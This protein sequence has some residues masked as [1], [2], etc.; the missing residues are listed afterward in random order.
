MSNPAQKALN[1]IPEIEFYNKLDDDDVDD[2]DAPDNNNIDHYLKNCV[3]CYP[4]DYIKKYVRQLVRNYDNY[5]VHLRKKS[6]DKYCR[7][8]IYWLYKSKKMKFS[9]LDT[10]LRNQ[11][12]KCIPCVWNQL[13]DNAYNQIKKC[14]FK[15]EN[16][17]FGVTQVQKALEEICSIKEKLK[18]DSKENSNIEECSK[19]NEIKQYYL[20]HI[21]YYIGSIS[22]NSSWKNEYFKVDN[23]CSLINIY[24]FLQEKPCPTEVKKSCPEPEVHTTLSPKPEQYC[25]TESCFN[26]T[27][28]RQKVCPSQSSP[29]QREV[30][31][32]ECPTLTCKNVEHICPQLCTKRQDP[33]PV[34]EEPQGN[35]NKNPLL[36][37]PVTVLSSVV[38][39]IFFFLLLYKFTPFRSWF[40]NRIG[41]KKTLNHKMRQEM[42]REFLG[43]PF[44]P[45]YGND[46]NSRPRVGYSQN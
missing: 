3:E 6:H 34:M 46:Q 37:V 14:N 1:E 31:Q 18:N 27:E 35:S 33:A 2:D 24:D 5:K 10:H 9:E 38:G 32:P 13:E 12:N 39:T 41:S 19:I 16:I 43:A 23:T 45:L 17:S 21:L 28:L 20:N 4:S 8:F 30:I 7:F 25:S 29:I 40:L 42:E 11:W 22:S 15:N 36:Q 26:L 44:Q